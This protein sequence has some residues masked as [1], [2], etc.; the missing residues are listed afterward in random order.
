MN[1]PKRK[2]YSHRPFESLKKKLP[3]PELPDVGFYAATICGR[4]T[5]SRGFATTPEQAAIRAA[6]LAESS[7][8]IGDM[9]I[10]SQ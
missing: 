1:Q 6:Q 8:R 2:T 9:Q 10:L 7:K 4:D 5:A 3:E